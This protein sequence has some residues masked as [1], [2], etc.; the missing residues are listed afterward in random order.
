MLDG[1]ISTVLKI[2]IK[3]LGETK[4]VTNEVGEEYE[5][6]IAGVEDTKTGEE[7]KMII[8]LRAFAELQEGDLVYLKHFFAKPDKYED[9][10][11]VLTKGK[12]GQLITLPKRR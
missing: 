6:A 1:P 2:I 9:D 10:K 8:S 4:K 12:H 7:M 11:I 3:R 5:F